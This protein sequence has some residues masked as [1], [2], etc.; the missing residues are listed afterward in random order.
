MR[1]ATRLGLP[2]VSFTL[3]PLSEVELIKGVITK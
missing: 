2:Y 3:V 1:E